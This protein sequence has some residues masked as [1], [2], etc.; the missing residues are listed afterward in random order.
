V[1]V[2][3]LHQGNARYGGRGGTNEYINLTVFSWSHR[4]RERECGGGVTTFVY[5][6]PLNPGERASLHHSIGHTDGVDPVHYTLKE[7]QN[8]TY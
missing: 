7:E 1:Q 4:E 5:V 2:T 8:T 6:D 3:T